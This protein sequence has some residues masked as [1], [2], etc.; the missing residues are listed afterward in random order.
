MTGNLTDHERAVLD[1]ERKRWRFAAQKDQAIRD[2]FN[3]TPIRY[4]QE[5][6]ALLDRPEA[7]AHDPQLVKRLRRIRDQHRQART[8]RRL[9]G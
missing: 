2:L 9:A 6:T 3:I 5:L 8:A 4:A 1:F 7:L